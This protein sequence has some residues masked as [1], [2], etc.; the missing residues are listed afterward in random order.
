MC[1]LT[2]LPTGVQPNREHLEC[3]AQCN[4]H[5]HGFGIVIPGEEDVFTYRGM[6]AADVIETFMAAREEYPQGP[7]LFHSRIT[8][9]GT[10]DESNCHPFKVAGDSRTVVAHNGVLPDEAQ[11]PAAKFWDEKLKR[12]ITRE[13]DTR[14][15]TRLFADEI[16][17]RDYHALD[18]SKTRDRLEKWLGWNNKLVVLTTDTERFE[19]SAYIFNEGLGTWDED[20][21]WYSNSSY[22]PRKVYKPSHYSTGWDWDVRKGWQRHWD[23]ETRE[24]GKQ[25]S[26]FHANGWERDAQGI[27]VQRETEPETWEGQEDEAESWPVTLGGTRVTSQPTARMESCYVCGVADSVIADVGICGNCLSCDDCAEHLTDCVCFGMAL[28]HSPEFRRLTSALQFSGDAEYVIECWLE[29]G[30][31]VAEAVD[32]QSALDA[33]E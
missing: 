14:S 13:V 2:Y 10:T 27:W 4:P 8:T 6:N 19:S 20:G 12:V 7:A 28:R 17:M 16:L 18:H 25:R 31:A 30:E 32:L 11:P 21:C 26:P 24:E 29:Y 3:G 5:G 9:A 33:Q 22:L 15:D 23:D 1:L